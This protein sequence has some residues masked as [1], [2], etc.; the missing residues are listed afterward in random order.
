MVFDNN[1]L[2]E[3]QVNSLQDKR[4]ELFLR[5]ERNPASISQRAFYV[6]VILKEAHRHDAFIHYNKYKDLHD[7]VFAPIFLSY[8]DADGNEKIKNLRDL[9]E[10]E[11]WDLT[12]RV[13]AY[14][15]SE[16]GIIISDK[17]DYYIK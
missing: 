5:E 1:Q 3:K 2:F 7:K 9:S 11:M 4:F 13:I 17:K 8:Y 10:Q 15:A 12:E 6:G 16:F 14:L